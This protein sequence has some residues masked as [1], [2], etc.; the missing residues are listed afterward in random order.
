MISV[1]FPSRTCSRKYG[2]YGTRTRDSPSIARD[3]AQKLIASSPRR[4]GSHQPRRGRRGDRDAA[5]FETV[6]AVL[7][8]CHVCLPEREHVRL[9]AGLEEADLQCSLADRLLLTHELVQATIPKQ[10]VPVLVD[11]YAV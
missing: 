10:S 6:V 1:T 2:E 9:G 11:V 4:I 3:P 7:C 5:W 8:R